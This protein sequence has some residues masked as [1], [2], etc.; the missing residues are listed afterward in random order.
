MTDNV[1]VLALGVASIVLLAT[2]FAMGA[3]H[4]VRPDGTGEFPTIQSAIESAISGDVIELADGTFTGP[5]NRSVDF[6]GKAITVRSASG[7]PSACII[8]CEC[9]ARGFLFVT[10]EPPSARLEAV[11]IQY[12]CAENAPGGGIMC[13]VSEPSISNVKIWLCSA[14]GG[15]GMY[16]LDSSPRLTD[17]TFEMDITGSWRN[18]GGLLCVGGSPALEG[19]VF[20]ECVAAGSIP[21]GSS[22]YGGG[23]CSEDSSPVL[24]GV[25]FNHNQA[26]SGGGM[27][28]FGG[29]PSLTDVQFVENRVVYGSACGMYCDSPGAVLTDVLFADNEPIDEEVGHLGGMFCNSATLS[30]VLFSGNKRGTME[31]VGSPSLTNVTFAGN[32]G[33]ISCLTGSPTLSHVTFWHNSRYAI[34]CDEGA[35]DIANTIIAFTAGAAISSSCLGTCTASLSCCDVVGNT[36]GNWTGPIADQLGIN[37]NIQRNPLFCDE[38]AGD[39]T[40]HD[41]SPCAPFSPPNSQ[42]DLIGAWPLGGCGP[43]PVE[44]MS[45]GA[46]K[47][48]FR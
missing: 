32:D 24:T 19:V 41:N 3:T 34:R 14:Q 37:G 36:G 15:G 47:A 20:H 1:G 48:L 43:S 18:G 5:G 11:T 42:C 12:A 27:A 26:Q 35:L 4:T 30:G 9:Q 17:V 6:L 28:S 31:C 39:W 16:T 33:G 46:V 40:L 45:W 21:G 13:V 10:G 29:S 22:P 38:W 2:G 8:D 23:M 7:D 44:T 25:L